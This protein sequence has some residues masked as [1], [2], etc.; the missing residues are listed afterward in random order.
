MRIVREGIELFNRREYERGIAGLPQEIVWDTSTAV[1]DG[2]VHSGRERVL[3]YGAMSTPDGTTSG[4]SPSAGSRPT[5]P[6]SCWGG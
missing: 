4:S 3:A 1:P 6:C 2:A 5:A